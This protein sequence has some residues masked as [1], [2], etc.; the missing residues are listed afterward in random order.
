[1][2]VADLQRTWILADGTSFLV[3]LPLFLFSTFGT[4]NVRQRDHSYWSGEL[5]SG[6]GFIQELGSNLWVGGSSRFFQR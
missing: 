3:L 6:H 1:M 4:N 2:A 5:T